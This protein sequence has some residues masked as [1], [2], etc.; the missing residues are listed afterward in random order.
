MPALPTQGSVNW[1]GWATAVESACNVAYAISDGTNISVGGTIATTSSVTAATVKTTGSVQTTQQS[2]DPAGIANVS[3]LW[4][5]TSDGAL[6]TRSGTGSV[7]RLPMFLGVGTAFPSM[8]VGGQAGDTYFR[9][10]VGVIGSLWRWNTNKWIYADS[11]ILTFATAAARDSFTGAYTGLEAITTDGGGHCVYAAAQPGWVPLNTWVRTMAVGGTYN[12]GISTSSAVAPG[13]VNY[14][15]VPAGR[16]LE[17]EFT[18]LGHTTGAIAHVQLLI[19]GNTVDTCTIG[20]GAGADSWE[21]IK[22][23]GSVVGTD[24]QVQ[25]YVT[26]LNQTGG[27]SE[28]DIRALPSNPWYVTERHRII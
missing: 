13:S 15:W 16:T 9:S 20:G 22:M 7:N 11:G 8:T 5:K 18:G 14:A 2:S 27:G 24:A 28:A 10:D 21:T 26:A 1:Y 4:S 3:Q 23:L 12:W 19:N 25:Y 6:Y 17:V